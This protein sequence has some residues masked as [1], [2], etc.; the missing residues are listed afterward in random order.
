MTLDEIMTLYNE[1]KTIENELSTEQFQ[2]ILDAESNIIGN[3]KIDCDNST[4]TLT[5]IDSGLGT[6][7]TVSFSCNDWQKHILPIFHALFNMQLLL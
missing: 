4:I 1:K 3:V 7:F 2:D 6:E 5:K